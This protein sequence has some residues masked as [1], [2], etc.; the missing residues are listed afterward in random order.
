MTD[1]VLAE[2]LA[3]LD[4]VVFERLPGGVLER[5]GAAPPPPWFTRVFPEPSPD[6]T[7]SVPESLPFLANFLA[8]A[9]EVWRS[10]DEPRLRSDPFTMSDRSGEEITLVASA[11]LVGDRC[12]LVLEVPGGFEERRRA[13]QTARENLLQHEKHLDQT[14]ALLAPIDAAQKMAQQLTRSGLMPDQ[15]ELAAGIGE[16]LSNLAASIESLAPLPKGVSRQTR[17]Q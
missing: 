13:L 4:L 7:A 6:E 5:I 11:L 12:L 8:D 17:R 14:R 10:G 3:A 2:I 9:E 16:Q 1:I 15:R